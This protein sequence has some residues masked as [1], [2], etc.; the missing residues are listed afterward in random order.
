VKRRYT[1]SIDVVRQ[2][3]KQFGFLGLY[4]GLSILLL[5]SVFKVSSRFFAYEELRGVF[6]DQNGNLSPT[7]TFLCGAGAGMTEAIVAVCPMETIKVRMIDDLNRQKPQYRGL[8][9]G[10]SSIYKVEGV[11]GMYKGLFP[12][13]LKQASNQAIR[14][15]VYGYCLKMCFGD[16][17]SE[18][19]YRVWQKLT[20]GVI[21]GAASVYGNNP[22][23]VIKTTCRVCRRRSTKESGIALARFTEQMAFSG[24]TGALGLA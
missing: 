20:A 15:F 10:V 22:F 6:M 24:S 3:L 18:H 4:R 8:F 11:G 1:G 21:A 14:F 2:T 9:H 19:E 16:K 12:T 17:K 23:D 13:I 7:R 5:G